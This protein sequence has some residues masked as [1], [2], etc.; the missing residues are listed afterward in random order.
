[1][2]DD[3]LS[4]VM[5][6]RSRA[7]S[8]AD[9][10][11]AFA[12]PPPEAGRRTDDA[13]AQAS[14][15]RRPNGRSSSTRKLPSTQRSG[16]R[17]GAYQLRK[18]DELDEAGLFYDPAARQRR[19]IGRASSASRATTGMKLRTVS[20][21]VDEVLYD[22]AYDLRASIVGFNLP[23]DISRLAIKHGSA[24]GKAMRGGF[25]FKLSRHVVAAGDPS[26]PPQRSRL[27]DPIHAS[28]EAARSS[29]A[30]E[31]EDR[32]PQ[33]ARL[34]HRF[35][36]DRRGA[37]QPFVLARVARRLP[38]D[39]NAQSRKRRP[40]EATDGEISS[41][42]LLQDVQVTWECYQS[43]RDR[44]ALHALEE[45]PLGKI[46]SEASLGKAYLKQMGVR[47]FREVQPDFPAAS[48][49]PDYERLFRRPGRG[50]LA[51]GNSP[52]AL[53]RFPLHVSDRLHPH[54]A[55]ALRHCS[56]NGMAGL[57][58]RK[59]GRSSIRFRW[60][61]CSGPNFGRC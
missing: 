20:E 40:W 21:F 17:I 60:R 13:S 15:R 47:P 54:G 19:R 37:A 42:T 56:G 5:P 11:R 41:A 23:F 6:G 34:I 51:A 26:S 9:R 45:T 32:A 7:R 4:Q 35:E 43:L 57:R 38:Q 61:N 53:L 58:P 31:A 16:L 3:R 48:D 29:W 49:R 59:P 8:L 24:R 25:T 33:S 55:M 1:M 50:A 2:T 44:Y 52:G 39:A 10:G 36:D 28:A 12:P 18:G 27:A 46:L 14:P 22:R 30:T